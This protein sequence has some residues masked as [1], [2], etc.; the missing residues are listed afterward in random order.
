MSE[1]ILLENSLQ[2]HKFELNKK[3]AYYWAV[4]LSCGRG[5]ARTP[6]LICVIDAL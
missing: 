1:K 6:D 2:Y 5:G 4:F 3:T